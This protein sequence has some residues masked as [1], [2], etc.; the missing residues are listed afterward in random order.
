MISTM[1]VLVILTHFEIAKDILFMVS[2]LFNQI[3]ENGYQISCSL[4]P[5]KFFCSY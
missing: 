4:V 1:S 2:F 3:L 5:R